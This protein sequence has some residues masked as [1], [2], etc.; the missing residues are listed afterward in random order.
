M[1]GISDQKTQMAFME[2]AHEIEFY[3]KFSFRLTF[4]NVNFIH[5]NKSGER[6]MADLS[7]MLRGRNFDFFSQRSS[8]YDNPLTFVDVF[9]EPAGGQ[10]V[11]EVTL[12]GPGSSETQTC[13]QILFRTYDVTH[14]D[15]S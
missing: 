12:L 11:L 9:G 8:I 7:Q 15:Y 1:I 3:Y 6:E 14:S 2:K 5:E 4:F 13:M 10:A